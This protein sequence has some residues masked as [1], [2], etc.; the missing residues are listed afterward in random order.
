MRT[1]LLLLLVAICT[2]FSVLLLR[3][4]EVTW[5]RGEQF[6][7]Q[8]E[9]NRYFTKRE[10]AERGIFLDRYGEPLVQN[11]KLYYQYLHK[12]RVYSDKELIAASQAIEL[13]ATDSASV[14][15]EFRRHYLYGGTLSHVLGYLSPVTS[16]DLSQERLALNSRLGRL[17]LEQVFERNLHSQPS[18]SKYEVNAL[19]QKQRLAVY[20]PPEFG[21]NINTA[22]DP[23]LS[24]LAQQAMLGLQGAVVIMDGATGE[25]L[26]LLSSPQFD[27][28]LLDDASPAARQQVATYLRDER[29]VFFNRASSGTYP[30]GSVFKMVTALGALQEGVI[31]A[32]T[33]VEDQGQLEVG[34]FAYANWYFTQYGRVDGLINVRR[35]LSRSNDIFFYKAAEWLGPSK[36]AH[37]ARLFG[38]GQP[39]GI[40]LPGEAAG[41]VPDPT[42]KEQTRGENWYLGNTYHLGIG[43]GDLLVTPLQVANMTQALANGGVWCQ[44]SLLQ[45][46]RQRNCRD[47][48]LQAAAVELV[49]AGM[50]DACSQGGTA[51][52]LFVYNERQPATL[53]CK[54]GTA[55]FGGAD[56]RGFRRTHAWLTAIVDLNQV[57]LREEWR[58][59]RTALPNQL[60]ITVLVESDESK[61][62]REGSSDAAP[63]V[64]Q[65]LQGLIAE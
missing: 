9:S 58:E 37:Y 1:K 4:L 36:L 26:T 62:F 7:A 46:S 38:L 49:L 43:Q 50:T 22:L 6:L 15:H 42:W 35:A 51:Y 3:L 28:N 17:G 60:V 5:W 31:Q 39:T 65:V 45:D 47:L 56:H 27:V 23:H 11:I 41:L 13:L 16:S 32:D 64:A 2:V 25:V 14:T 30:P 24:Q 52:P 53:A 12:D 48:G 61:P 19:G 20:A 59:R 34:D 63:V 21:Q 57:Q 33:E 8:A 10:P 54:T 29:Q 40:Q 55:E 18:T 44:A